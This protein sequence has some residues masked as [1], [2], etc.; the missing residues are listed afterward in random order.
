MRHRA[1]IKKVLNRD[2]T[3]L[4]KM[5]DRVPQT[6]Q[7]GDSRGC[8]LGMAVKHLHKGQGKVPGSGKGWQ[9]ASQTGRGATEERKIVERERARRGGGFSQ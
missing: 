5:T 6:Q 1:Q 7:K 8:D 2:N 9:H 4:L 3:R